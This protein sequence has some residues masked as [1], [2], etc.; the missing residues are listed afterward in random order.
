MS[1]QPGPTRT[2]GPSPSRVEL[3]V[4]GDA[5]VRERADA[6]RNRRRVLAA[7]ER[8]FAE[9][10]VE[11]VS[12]DDVVA[13]A[14]VGKGTLYRRFG[15]KS[16]LAVALLDERKRELQQRIL[17]G[18]PPLGPD[19]PP[20][21]RLVAFTVAYLE[22]VSRHLDLVAM[23]QTASPGARLRSGAHAF[24]RQHVAYL[25]ASAGTADPALRAD[26]LLAGLSAEQLIHWLRDQHQPL[27]TLQAALS[28]LALELASTP[29]A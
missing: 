27:D 22:Y 4:L 17:T 12:M 26:V 23:S 15:D 25:L 29:T 7:A 3:P 21:Q 9:R 14:G 13:A 8:L 1:E 20:S 10:G 5:A 2:P 24:W 16:G 18:P 6:S 28:A 11:A 19:A